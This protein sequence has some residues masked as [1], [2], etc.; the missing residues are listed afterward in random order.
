LNVRLTKGV[1]KRNFTIRGAL[2]DIFML[3]GY[4]LAVIYN[5]GQKYQCS[6]CA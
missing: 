1:A 2:I 5:R 6:S 3:S 4:W